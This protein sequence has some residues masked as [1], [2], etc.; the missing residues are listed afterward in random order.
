MKVLLFTTALLLGSIIVTGCLSFHAANSR[1]ES[2]AV[3]PTNHQETPAEVSVCQLAADP[4]KYNHKL[5]KL[6]GF[7]SHGFEDSSVY[8][9]A[10][11][12][13]FNIWFE[14]GGKNVTG[15]MY[16][17]G[18]TAARERPEMIEVENISIPLLVNDQFKTFDN[19]LHSSGDSIVHATV[20]GRFF[21]GEKTKV[22]NGNERWMGYGH[23][24]MSS[25]L[26]IQEVSNTDPRDRKDLDYRASPDQPSLDS[27]GC[28]GY[29]ILSDSDF[30][31]L[32]EM[33]R[34]A[35]AGARA[36]VFEDSKRV[37]VEALANLTKRPI[38]VLTTLKMV[39]QT[40]GRLIYEWR[41]KGE[42]K[43][44]MIVVSRPYELS[45]YAK[46]NL[47]AWVPIAAYEST[48]Q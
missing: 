37:A 27:R 42:K 45:F 10:C 1:A 31:S 38:E 20:I 26:M 44:Y 4:A 3:V 14:Y 22:A 21:S 39:R 34:Q 48:C 33:Q 17:C 30:E 11:D 35:D 12:S 6:T 24:G 15:T 28:T 29:R 43:I 5:V 19:L 2:I 7:F 36:W 9:P 47:V 46:S 25:L 8:D 32:L 16:C 18:V 40:Q 41:P 23:M 13:R